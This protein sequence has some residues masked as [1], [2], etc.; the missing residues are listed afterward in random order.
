MSNKETYPSIERLKDRYLKTETD[1]TACVKRLRSEGKSI[2]T[3]NGCFDLLHRGHLC[4]LAAAAEQGDVLI[5]G[6]NSDVS[7]KKGKGPSRPVN[8]QDERAEILLALEYV[9]CVALFDE[10]DCVDFVRRVHPDVHVND[11]SYGENCIESGAV[12]EGGGRLFLVDKIPT[13][14]TTDLIAKIESTSKQ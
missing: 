10:K 7:V 5:V 11:S 8:P 1:L 9:D 12:R 2:V 6:L 13:P 4:L 3:T 14:S